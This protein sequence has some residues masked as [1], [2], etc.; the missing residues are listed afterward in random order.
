MSLFFSMIDIKEYTQA[1]KQILASYIASHHYDI[2]LTIVQ[3]GNNPASNAYIKGKIA[4]CTAAGI[5]CVLKHYPESIT[6][7]ELLRVIQ[8]LNNDA[9][10]DSFIVQLPL[11]PHINE[12]VVTAA[13]DSRKDVD[14]FTATALVNPATPQGIVDYLEANNFH[15]IN[16]NVVIIGRSNIVGRPLARLMLDKSCNVSVIH[17]KTGLKNKRLLTKNADLVIV[18]T[19]HR[20][21]L[22][23]RDVKPKCWVIDVGINRNEQGKLCGD[24]ENLTICQKTPVP[25]GVGLLTRLALLTNA[26]KLYERT[27]NQM[28]FKIE[29]TQ[30]YGIEAA[31]VNSGNS[32][33]TELRPAEDVNEKDWKRARKLGAADPG[34]GHDTF[35]SGITVTADFIAP[36]YWWKQAQRYHWFEFVSSQSTMHCV[37]KFDIKNQ[38]VEETDPRVIAVVQ[39]LI[40]EYNKE[41]DVAA[42]KATWH[43]IIASLPCGFCLGASMVTN[44]RQLKTMYLQRKNHPLSE[45]HDF[46]DWCESLPHFLVLCLGYQYLI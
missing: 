26:V 20:N 38:C 24:C 37:L 7:D 14:G 18:A 1:K 30:V 33:R 35:L 4:D 23:N 41:T 44:Y 29:K 3:V 32:Y 34:S 13:I 45:W 27:K 43:R 19:G 46:C 11:P 15:F 42:K 2:C 21:T 22:E 10:V 6:Q 25:G 39:E 28:N 31:L 8:D 5:R 17:S 12:K 36:L 16:A 9:E 40:D